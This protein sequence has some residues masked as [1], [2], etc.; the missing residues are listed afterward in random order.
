VAGLARLET[1][2]HSGLYEE[3]A[4]QSEELRALLAGVRDPILRVRFARFAGGAQLSFN[5]YREALNILL[6]GR[7]LAAKAEIYRIFGLSMEISP[8]FI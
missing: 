6:P 2:L 7:D 8:G 1:F 5:R 4:A 3:A